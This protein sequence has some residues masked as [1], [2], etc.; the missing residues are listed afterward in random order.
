MFNLCVNSDGG[1]S[2]EGVSV[3]SERKARYICSQL[4]SGLRMDL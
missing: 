2:R 4:P 1:D 3:D